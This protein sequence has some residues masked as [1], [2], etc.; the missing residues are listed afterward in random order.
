M[1]RLGQGEYTWQLNML[2]VIVV[3]L[4]VL[5]LIRLI[6][7]GKKENAKCPIEKLPAVLLS[8]EATA[9]G[10]AMIGR[11][12]RNQDLGMPHERKKVKFQFENGDTIELTV[13]ED[14]ISYKM[15][16]KKGILEYQGAKLI[17]FQIENRG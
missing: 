4:I 8:I 3:I 12:S 11:R 6:Y 15:I 10:N 7:K 2:A 17:S 5:F 9:S 14:M 13:N 1:G 16:G